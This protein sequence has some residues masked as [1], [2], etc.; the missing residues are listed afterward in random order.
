MIKVELS[1]IKRGDEYRAVI[2]VGENPYLTDKKVVYH[3]SKE[4]S[5]ETKNSRIDE[6]VIS[7]EL[8][9]EAKEWARKHKIPYV[10]NIDVNP[11]E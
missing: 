8:K 7:R 5:R 1:I 9:E 11:Y 3:S 4:I 6:R 2:R 10:I